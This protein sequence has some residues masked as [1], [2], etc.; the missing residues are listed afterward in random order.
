MDVSVSDGMSFVAVKTYFEYSG[1]SN[2][3]LYLA[4]LSVGQ[5]AVCLL[6]L[7]LFPLQKCDET[8]HTPEPPQLRSIVPLALL[9]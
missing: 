9:S 1:C 7:L 6:C 2:Q 5:L 8:S 4:F 3:L